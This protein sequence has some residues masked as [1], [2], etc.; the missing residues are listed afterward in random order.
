MRVKK[1]LLYIFRGKYI[2][3]F[4]AILIFHKNAS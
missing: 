3:D 4:D 1:I 2:K